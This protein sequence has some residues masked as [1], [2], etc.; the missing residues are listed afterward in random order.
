MSLELRTEADVLGRRELPADALYGINI[1]R[2][3]E[4]FPLSGWLLADE[5]E[6]VLA[7]A[8][9]KLA[10]ARA[11]HALGLLSDEVFRAASEACDAVIRGKGREALKVDMLEGSGGTST[12]MNINEV[13]AN[14]ALCNLGRQP[15]QYDHVHPIDHLNCGQS[16]SDVIPTALKIASFRKVTRIVAKLKVLADRFEELAVREAQTLQLARACIQD[17]LPMTAG[18]RFAASA[19]L[20]RRLA[21]SLYSTQ[22]GLLSIN[23]GGTAIGT[24]CGASKGYRERATEELIVISNLSLVS[25]GDLIDST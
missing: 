15:G 7:L 21:A 6:Y 10:S 1:L 9:T 18:Q 4:N 19:A 23:L 14:L 11:N 8:Q 22:Q 12:N 5:P 2:G 16:T 13:L 3:V 24:G 20:A 17:A 25:A